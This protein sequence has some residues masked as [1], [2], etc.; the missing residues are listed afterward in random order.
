VHRLKVRGEEAGRGGA[1]GG[2]VDL[3]VVVIELLVVSVQSLSTSGARGSVESGSGVPLGRV[4]VGG[5]GLGRQGGAG[6]VCAY[7]E[8][9]DTQNKT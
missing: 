8:D 9:H 7:Q 6:V 5:S 1:G 2:D 4:L 3:V